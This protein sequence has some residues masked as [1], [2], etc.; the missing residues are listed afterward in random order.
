MAW[1]ELESSRGIRA[2]TMTRNE[3]QEMVD[4]HMMVIPALKDLQYHVIIESE[5][6]GSVEVCMLLDV[7]Q[8]AVSYG[9]LL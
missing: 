6:G 8:I 5:E 4:Y 3:E 9:I 2:F 7:G 1:R